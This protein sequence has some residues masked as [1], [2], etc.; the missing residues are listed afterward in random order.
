[1]EEEVSPFAPR[2]IAVRWQQRSAEKRACYY[3]AYQLARYALDR[4][5]EESSGERPPAVILDID[6]TVLD[7]S[8][9][10]AR[11]V[12]PGVVVTEQSLIK[13][14]EEWM[15]SA[16]AEVQPGAAGFLRYA[17]QRGVTPFYVSNRPEYM[18]QPT[19]DNLTAQG[20]PGADRDH[21]VLQ[22]GPLNFLGDKVSQWGRVTGTFE[23]LLYVGD[24]LGDMGGAFHDRGDDHGHCLVDERADDFG[25]R[26]IL[27]P[28]PMY[29]SW[30]GRPAVEQEASGEDH[31]D[32]D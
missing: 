29:G 20:C 7:N 25:V 4:A 10:F 17:V 21:V 3:Q 16:S 5:I 6:E 30:E 12:E 19:I 31:V 22:P 32:L 15:R 23:V 14:F 2:E 18:L 27:V 26:Y 13:G 1:M 28:N 11:L 24:S 8:P 9:F